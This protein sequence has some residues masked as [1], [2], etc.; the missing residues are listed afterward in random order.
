M[1]TPLA[2]AAPPLH[3]QASFV[4]GGDGAAA[5]HTVSPHCISAV[6][7][8][9]LSANKAKI[10]IQAPCAPTGE[11]STA[12][13]ATDIKKV[14]PT[15]G[16][17][18][19]LAIDIKRVHPGCGVKKVLLQMLQKHPDWAITEHRVN[20][21]LHDNGLANV[22]AASTAAANVD[23]SREAQVKQH[24]HAGAAVA[25]IHFDILSLPQPPS[26]STEH[27]DLPASP[28]SSN[29]ASPP[30]CAEMIDLDQL[31]KPVTEER[32]SNAALASH[33]SN[34]PSLPP[35]HS[36]ELI[37]LGKLFAHVANPANTQDESLV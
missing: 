18:L 9:A 28:P 35:S 19:A 11:C 36:S 5:C 27:C 8:G 13:V 31:F 24:D 17:M 37:D 3:F 4:G 2:G 29:P 7:N 26:D 30:P 21:L 12:A 23:T 16:D 1:S 15:P 32:A 25:D 20:K 33:A 22:K 34:C 6:H 14:V 10:S